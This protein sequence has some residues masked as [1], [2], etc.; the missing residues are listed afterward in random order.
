MHFLRQNTYSWDTHRL[1][2]VPYRE[3]FAL[4]RHV[5]NH[6]ET[7]PN[8][9]LQRLKQA[10]EV[11]ILLPPGYN[12][13]HVYM[14][15]GVTSALPELNLERRNRHGVTYRQVMNNFY[16]EIE[17][18]IRLGVSYDLFWNLEGL[19]LNG[20]REIVTI[21]ED[22]KVKVV[23]NGHSQILKKARMLQRP[24]GEPPQLAVQVAVDGET[25]PY[26]V[27]ARA[28]VIETTAPVYYAKGADK[29]GVY[30][31]QYVLWELFGPQ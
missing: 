7:H 6:A 10:A 2:C 26:K 11:A 16:V 17:R 28:R 14:G 24:Q 15:R 22:G 20:Y 23:Q 29:N 25:P 4:S 19:E 5:R 3:I 27:T 1:A 12:L 13:G 31:N 30:R 18:C 21:R 8:R 9:N